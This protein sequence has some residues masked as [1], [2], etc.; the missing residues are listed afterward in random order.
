V[1]LSIRNCL[2]NTEI[3]RKIN[4]ELSQRAGTLPQNKDAKIII[5]PNFNSNMNALTGNTTDL[6]LIAAVLEFLKDFGFSN[7]T[8]AEG[9]NSGFYRRNIGVM[10]RLKADKIAKIYGA[11]ILDLNYDNKIEIEF[12]NGVKAGISEICVH[13]DFF[14][15]MPKLKMHYE[16]EM[17]VCLKSLVGCLVGM[18]NK[19]K[20]H[21][22]LIKNIYILNK[23]IKPDLH[24]VDAIIAMEGTGPTTGTPIKC[25]YVLIGESP[26]LLDL[27]CA[28]IAGV[29]FYEVPVL[30][31]AEERENITNGFHQYLNE[32]GIDR[33]AKNFKRPDINWLTALVSHKKLQK[34]F[35]KIRHAPIVKT[36]FG[37]SLANRIMFKVGLTQEIFLKD[38]M[39][40]NSLFLNKTK[41]KGTGR[42][43]DFCPVGLELP[44][45]LDHPDCIKCFYCF[46]IC[47]NRAI[48]V[49]GTLGFFEEQLRQY[50]DVIRK[51]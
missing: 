24:I 6:R 22:N 26:F 23:I 41:C 31:L 2:T 43:S 48:Q 9:T 33:Y 19:K 18:E 44:E 11:K 8:I 34:Y 42:C 16:T 17:T 49:K 45:Q 28:R 14:I 35:L 37:T 38:D 12:E 39:E 3:K 36:V 10:S 40:E 30:K 50:D 5:K 47:K 27:A 25:G 1:D 46:S 20:A 15:N 32:I 51:L 4:E 13:N 7:I 21:S 29:P